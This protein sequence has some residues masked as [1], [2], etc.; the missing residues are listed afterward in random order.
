M[1]KFFSKVV[2]FIF[3]L[4]TKNLTKLRTCEKTKDKATFLIDYRIKNT[5]R[6]RSRTKASKQVLY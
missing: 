4:S 3:F 1:N 2:K 5:M 6:K